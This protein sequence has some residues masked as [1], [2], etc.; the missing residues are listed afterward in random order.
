MS[1]HSGP[2]RRDMS[3]R[4]PVPAYVPSPPSTPLPQTKVASRSEVSLPPLPENWES[5]VRQANELP[6]IKLSAPDDTLDGP[7]N[8]PSDK[9]EVSLISHSP[10]GRPKRGLPQIYRPPTPPLVH[11]NKRRNFEESRDY[12]TVPSP[13]VGGHD[14]Y[15]PPS[16]GLSAQ[17]SVR[18]SILTL[19]PQPSVR[20]EKTMVS[21]HS[22]PEF[23]YSIWQSSQLE[24]WHDLPV[25]SM[26]IVK[27]RRG[28]GSTTSS[29]A[30]DTSSERRWL[31][32]RW[33][34]FRSLFHGCV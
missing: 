8:K 32:K 26:H 25:L 24:Q 3:Y 9:A 30:S 22:A 21:T 16:V 4:K 20:T 12:L 18:G 28:Y 15:F 17:S 33:S 7:A 5:S 31:G 14:S 6:G 19:T 11:D 23:R 29:K 1:A 34:A 13:T 27:P 2:I 10:A